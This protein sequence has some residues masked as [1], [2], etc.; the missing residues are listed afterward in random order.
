[1]SKTFF[2]VVVLYIQ[3]N[4]VVKTDEETGDQFY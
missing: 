4:V 2:N 3:S 1:M